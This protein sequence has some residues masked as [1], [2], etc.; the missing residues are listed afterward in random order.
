ML[1]SR[2]ISKLVLLVLL[3]TSLCLLGTSYSYSNT[4]STSDN[5]CTTFFASS[6]STTDITRIQQ[7]YLTK[8]EQAETYVLN[9]IQQRTTPLITNSSNHSFPK[10]ES[11]PT[12]I[13][14]I[15]AGVTQLYLRE[16]LQNLVRFYRL[17]IEKI[18]SIWLGTITG[19]SSITNQELKQRI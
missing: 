2:L 3:L 13:S 18:V 10:L 6:T 19:I 17:N 4:S 16:E 15:K 14:S 7:E 5:P 9:A 8:L 1:V 12:A 11:D